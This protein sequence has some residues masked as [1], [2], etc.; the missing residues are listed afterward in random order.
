M[1]KTKVKPGK[2]EKINFSI[3]LLH[4]TKGNNRTL[5]SF[6]HKSFITGPPLGEVHDKIT[7]FTHRNYLF[8][9]YGYTSIDTECQV[10]KTVAPTTG[11]VAPE[12]R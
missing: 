5:A 4:F 3:N 12:P 8:W 2:S 10:K 1:T 7:L 11:L 6:F 9:N